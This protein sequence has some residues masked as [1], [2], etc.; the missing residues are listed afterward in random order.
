MNLYTECKSCGERIKIKSQAMTRSELEDQLGN[1]FG[2]NCPNCGQEE[3]YHVNEVFAENDNLIRKIGTYA[4]VL[5]IALGLIF[6]RGN[7]T[8]MVLTAFTAAAIYI[9]GRRLSS[10]SEAELFN[11]IEISKSKRNEYL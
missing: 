4:S 6:A 7:Q 11:Q 10:G 3:T 2:K 5:I 9:G 8:L 1:Y